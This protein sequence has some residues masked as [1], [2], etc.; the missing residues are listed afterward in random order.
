MSKWMRAILGVL[1]II[2]LVSIWAAVRFFMVERQTFEKFL[3]V[4]RTLGQEKARLE[5]EL[6]ASEAEMNRLELQVDTL[7][8]LRTQLEEEKGVLLKEID[9]MAPRL[10][11]LEKKIE[12]LESEPFLANLLREKALLGVEAKALKEEIR[13]QGSQLGKEIEAKKR[14]A[15]ELKKLKIEDQVA[16]A[17]SRDLARAK[18]DKF[19]AI[20]TLGKL[21]GEN[22][23]LQ[24]R[25]AQ[26]A[27]IKASLGEKLLVADSQLQRTREERD[28]LAEELVAVRLVL[29]EREEEV[30]QVRAKLAKT[31]EETKEIAGERAASIELPPIVVKAAMAPGGETPAPLPQGRI[32]TVNDEYKFVVIDLG[33]EHGVEAGTSFT[34]YRGDKEIG[35]L[36]V[37]EAHQ[38]ISAADIKKVKER[39]NIKVD[40]I[41]V[42]TR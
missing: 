33:K 19:V 36:E 21:E 40:D 17:L 12:D 26:L 23:D 1:V 15:T 16:E 42:P 6:S 29:R 28:R 35:Y 13:S 8:H 30:D 41:V 5:R 22:R 25:M 27:K 11:E 9:N 31:I 38:R 10:V 7:A 2:S 34:V 18:R 37:I 4:K 39:A 24:Q 3:E 32:V 14:L 20:E